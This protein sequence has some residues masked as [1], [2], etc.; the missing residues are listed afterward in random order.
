MLSDHTFLITTAALLGVTHTLLGPDHYIPF[1]A[2][3]KARSWS[4]K[5]TLLITI[6]SGFGHVLSSVI[7]GLLLVFLGKEFLNFEMIEKFRGPLAAWLLF[8]FGVA[9]TL[10]G[11]R[12]A[13]LRRSN[14]EDR[15]GNSTSWLI[16][17]IFALGPCE[18][19][20]PLLMTPAAAISTTMLLTVSTVFLFATVGTM[21]TVVTLGCKSIEYLPK[22]RIG[23]LAHAFAGGAITSCAAGMLFL[24]L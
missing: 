12:H 22:L 4:L 7:I 5:R 15:S 10:Y 19:L 14:T 21:C 20:I 2:L 9:Y 23:H 11:L 13:W 17:I 18:P 1:V 3:G 16:F 8:G 24:G 6:L